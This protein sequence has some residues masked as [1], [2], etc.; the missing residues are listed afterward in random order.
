MLQATRAFV[1]KPRCIYT[2]DVL[3]PLSE[4]L[5]PSHEHIIPLSLGG[6]NQ[7][8]T[9]DVSLTANSAAGEQIDDKVASSFPFLTLRHRYKLIGNRKT[10][11]SVKIS[12]EF[13]DINAPARLDINAAGN[14][15]FTFENEQKTSGQITILGSTEDRVRF[16]LRGRLE[17]AKQRKRRLVTEFGEIKDEEDIEVALLLADRNEG[18]EFKGKITIDAAAFNAA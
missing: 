16:L 9:D 4:Q 17:Q 1:S 10:I 6:S 13:V 14:L 2:A 3:D 7:F 15:E 8:T 11:P 18:R 5:K 12:G